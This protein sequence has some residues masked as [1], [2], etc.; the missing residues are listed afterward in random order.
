MAPA[1]C[2]LLSSCY[3]PKPIL[4]ALTPISSNF[5]LTMQCI[6]RHPI[7]FYMQLSLTAGL[8]QPWGPTPSQSHLVNIIIHPLI[9]SAAQASSTL[10]PSLTFSSPNWTSQ[11]IAHSTLL[12]YPVYSSIIVLILV[13]CNNVLNLWILSLTLSFTRTKTMWYSSF[14]NYT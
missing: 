12:V 14:F 3:F 6:L 10:G 1:Y 4:Y 11:Y 2:F 9:P 5:S 13:Y 8:P 7:L